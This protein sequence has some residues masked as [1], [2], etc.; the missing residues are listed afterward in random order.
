MRLKFKFPLKLLRNE[1]GILPWIIPAITAAGS[2][3]AA[4]LSRGGK[5]KGIDLPPPPAWYEDPYYPKTQEDLY[6]FGSEGLQGTVPAYYAALGEYGGPEF[7]KYNA[8]INK[9]ITTAAT[10][11]AARRRVRGGA[12]SEIIAKAVGE[13][14][15]KLRYADF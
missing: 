7:E 15:T 12:T 10:E 6:K 3:G 13:S 8:L 4:A 1:K 2:I 5:G 11:D 9:D 14:S